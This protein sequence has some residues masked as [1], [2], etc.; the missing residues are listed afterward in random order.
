MKMNQWIISLV[1]GVL[2]FLVVFYIGQTTFLPALFSG[3]IGFVF[4]VLIGW[5]SNRN[6]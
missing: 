4:N 2:M 1:V 5:N 3:L 6:N